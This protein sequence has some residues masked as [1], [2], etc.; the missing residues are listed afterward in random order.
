MRTYDPIEVAKELRF[1]L[2]DRDDPAANHIEALSRL[3]QI[4]E[5][6]R[7]YIAKVASP[8]TPV[9]VLLRNYACRYEMSRYAEKLIHHRKAPDGQIVSE[10]AG[11]V[12]LHPNTVTTVEGAIEGFTAN[13]GLEAVGL[14]DFLAAAF[15]IQQVGGTLTYNGVPVSP[16][17]LTQTGGIGHSTIS[18]DSLLHY[19]SVCTTLQ[20]ILP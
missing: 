16:T 7:A 6:S 9:A 12:F 10:C 1:S 3:I 14:F 15:Y 5:V 19:G 11:F 18:D 2:L 4:A 17:S 8:E 20:E 13:T